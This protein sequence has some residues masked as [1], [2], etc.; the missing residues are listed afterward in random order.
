VSSQNTLLLAK[1]SDGE[2]YLVNIYD[3]PEDGSGGSVELS[4]SS[5]GLIGAPMVPVVLVHDF[6]GLSLH[7]HSVR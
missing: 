7:L 5:V 1:E 2:L 3:K 6:F 4:L